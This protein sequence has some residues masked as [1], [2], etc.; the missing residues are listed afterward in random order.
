MYGKQCLQVGSMVEGCSFL[1]GQHAERACDVRRLPRQSF[2]SVRCGFDLRR[3]EVDPVCSGKLAAIVDRGGNAAHVALQK[4]NGARLETNIRV[5][6]L[7]VGCI[8]VGRFER[9]FQASLPP[10]RPPPLSLSPPSAEPTSI[11]VV[12]KLT[13]TTPQSDPETEVK[14]NE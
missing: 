1:K 11:P 4:R 10:S 14:R 2:S 7:I 13:L 3:V 12:G 9:T 6:P 8:G 5:E